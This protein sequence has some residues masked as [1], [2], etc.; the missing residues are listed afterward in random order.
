MSPT[1]FVEHIRLDHAK[2]LLAAGQTVSVAAKA[3]GF[4]STESMRRIFHQRL[5][6]SPRDYRERF[7]SAVHSVPRGPANH[8]VT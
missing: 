8:S 4:G 3:S 6:I 2:A 7:C 5:Q 1:R